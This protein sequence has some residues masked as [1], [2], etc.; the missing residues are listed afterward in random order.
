M[1]FKI[2]NK[3]DY[4]EGEVKYRLFFA[5]FPVCIDNE[6]RWFEFVKIK[7]VYR[8]FTTYTTEKI[9]GKIVPV[10]TDKK[11]WERDK[12]VPEDPVKDCPYYRD[13]GCDHVD[14]F[15]C[16]METCKILKDEY[17]EFYK[18]SF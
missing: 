4:I 8:R 3:K 12:F 10:P 9:G 14:G 2:R 1:R 5:I 6:C 18:N 16:D 15:L 7:Y 13:K 11:G 17:P